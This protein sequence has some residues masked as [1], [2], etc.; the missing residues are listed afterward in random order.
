MFEPR[1]SH[2]HVTV[3]QDL[4]KSYGACA[5]IAAAVMLGMQLCRVNF[6][7]A[8]DPRSTLLAAAA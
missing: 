2:V 5:T 1:L 4:S 7:V 3:T 6:D 8:L